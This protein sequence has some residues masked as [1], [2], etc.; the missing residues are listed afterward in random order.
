M[1]R[2][3]NRVNLGIFYYSPWERVLYLFTHVFYF[4]REEYSET[5]YNLL[6]KWN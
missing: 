6:S 2:V 4:T 5:C 3:F 1:Y